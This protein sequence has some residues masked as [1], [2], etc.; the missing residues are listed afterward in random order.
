M[1]GLMKVQYSPQDVEVD[2]FNAYVIVYKH[3]FPH[4]PNQSALYADLPPS[5]QLWMPP[6]SLYLFWWGGVGVV[7]TTPS[8]TSA[9][10][11]IPVL[12][13]PSNLNVSP[14]TT[15]CAALVSLSVWVLPVSV[16]SVPVPVYSIRSPIAAYVK[17]S[18]HQRVDGNPVNPNV[19]DHVL[20]DVFPPE[21]VW[22][23][24]RPYALPLGGIS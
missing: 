23:R 9:S 24:A 8:R 16:P 17:L 6:H 20:Q 10:A 5:R 21:S 2:T 4:P 12:S 18:F 3:C 7:T 1:A 15:S 14:D 13:Y 22:V 11:V 19:S